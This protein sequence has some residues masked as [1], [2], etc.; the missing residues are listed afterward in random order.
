M[1]SPDLDAAA[2]TF[3]VRVGGFDGPLDLLLDLIG[4]HELDITELSL[5]IVTDEF[6]AHL[7][8]L[9]DDADLDQTSGFLVVGATLLDAKIAGLLPAGEVVDAEAVAMLEARDLLFARLLQYRAYKEASAWFA[10]ALAVE[11]ARHAHPGAVREQQ[12]PPPPPTDLSVDVAAFALLAAAALAPRPVPTVGTDHLHGSAVGLRE[13]A[14]EVVSLLRRG[15]AMSFLDLAGP[16]AERPIVIARFLAVLELH[17]LGAIAFEQLDPLGAL[18][19]RWTAQDW[20]D[21]M[22]ARLGGG[23]DD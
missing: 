15:S 17:R 19:V 22:L 18:V 5:S 1:R 23:F 12:L 10:D 20:D 8:Q 3:R 7:A 11:D 21:T 4:R 6:L 16:E 14:A 13:Q 9:G 2:P